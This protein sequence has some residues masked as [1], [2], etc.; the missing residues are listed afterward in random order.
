MSSNVTYDT[1]AAKVVIVSPL[2]N[3]YVNT[4]AVSYTLS[5]NILSGQ[6]VI[7]QTGPISG[8]TFTYTMTSSDLTQGSHTL[9]TGF[10]LVNGSIYTI[11]FVNVL[12]LA[13]NATASVSSTNVT[14][15]TLSIGITAITPGIKSIMTSAVVGYTL[16]K[17]AASGTI[18]FT[19]TGGAP[20]PASPYTYVISSGDLGK[21]AHSVSTG[22]ALVEE[23]FYTITLQFSDM[24]GNPAT[25]MSNGMVFFDSNY[26]KGPVGNVANEDGLNIVNNADV[27]KMQRRHGQPARGPELEP[28]VRPEP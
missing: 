19:R 28:G 4:A 10:S 11:S 16:S 23:A 25:T 2:S 24:A 15:D 13:K 14:Y 12:D 7:T 22:L 9:T 5:E 17:D 6:L 21:G 27:L 18:T 8:P 3:T 1:T 20:D 26:G